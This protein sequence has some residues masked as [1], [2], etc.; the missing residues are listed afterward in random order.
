[1]SGAAWGYAGS[2]TMLVLTIGA[3]A[4]LARIVGPADFGAFAVG[5]LVVSFAGYLA[6]FGIGSALVAKK[7]LLPED[8]RFAF[9]VQLIIGI[10]LAGTMFLSAGVISR[11][12]DIPESEPVVQLL[13]LVILVMSTFAISGSLLHRDFGFRHQSIAQ[14]IAYV[15]GNFVIAVPMALA[16]FGALSMAVGWVAQSIIG[17]LY[18]WRYYPHP[19]RPL[20]R[21]PEGKGLLRFGGLSTV[22]LI[23]RYFANSIDRAIVGRL[24]DAAHLAF[25][26]TSINLASHPVGRL[27]GTLQGV[28]FSYS[29]RLND[30]DSGGAQPL[31]AT[32]EVST[33]IFAP[34]YLVMAVVAD[35]LILALYGPGWEPAGAVIRAAAFAMLAMS[36]TEISSPFLWG[37]GRGR[38]DT[39]GHIATAIVVVLLTWIGTHYGIAT[40]AWLMAAA[41]AARSLYLTLVAAHYLRVRRRTDL[42]RAMR[43]GLLV[44]VAPAVACGSLDWLM[45]YEGVPAWLRLVIVGIVAALL[46]VGGVLSMRGLLSS[47]LQTRLDSL[48]PRMAAAKG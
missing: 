42:L 4:I 7:D 27:L 21:Y 22:A 30:D 6:D 10:V 23:A 25:Y 20:F 11:L 16:G 44:A 19:I 29:S 9:T 1:M 8:I 24:T 38:A 43:P 13:S 12:I 34:L 33:L 36:F 2:M 35:T 46:T 3:Q 28:A 48:L 39:I 47:P 26:A 41:Y 40:T 15:I 37:F 18:I 14:V 17:G 45:T 5:I 32:I 31:L